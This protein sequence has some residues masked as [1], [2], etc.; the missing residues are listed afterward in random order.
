MAYEFKKLSDVAVVET[1][2]DTANVL[3][4]EG[5]VIKKVAKGEV[6]GVK[7]DT[8]KVGQTIVVKSVDKNGKPTEWECA[9]KGGQVDWDQ[10]DPT[11][12][13]YV[14]NRTHWTDEGEVDVIP[15]MSFV[16]SDRNDC[17]LY[18]SDV[19]SIKE[20]QTYIV[21]VD[22]IRY[23]C[24]PIDVGMGQLVI[25]NPAKYNSSFE[26]NGVPFAISETF[27]SDPEFWY[28]RFFGTKGIE[29]TVRVKQI[30][31]QVHT[32]DPKYLPCDL[33]FKVGCTGF[34]HPKYGTPDMTKPEIVSGSLE[35][36]LEKLANGEIPV[37]KVQY[38]GA[39]DKNISL[40]SA[41][42]GEFTCDTWLYG[43]DISFSHIVFDR[44]YLSKYQIIMDLDDLSYLGLLVTPYN[45]SSQATSFPIID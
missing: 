40:P 4:E 25:G 18:D 12:F 36:V 3:I 19:P 1:P 8:A 21:Y 33:M 17:N 29:Y 23:E 44:N 34:A 7:V 15:E 38:M 16:L 10:N 5:G 6:G 31:E 39:W 28:T 24:L 30:G 22:G 2:A 11:A 20:G 45:L 26:D 35:A 32:L 9:D 43:T 13:D 27:T 42:G 41:Y 37:V 14:K